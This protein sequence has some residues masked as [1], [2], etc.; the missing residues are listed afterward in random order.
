MLE[1]Q[2]SALL[3]LVL[4]VHLAVVWLRRMTRPKGQG[5][6]KRLLERSQPAQL[7]IVHDDF[8]FFG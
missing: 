1:L 8:F 6:L 7:Q 2:L 5:G 3:R 4:G